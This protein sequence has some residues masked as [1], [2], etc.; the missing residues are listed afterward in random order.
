MIY[1]FEEFRT[2][3]PTRL[4]YGLFGWPLGHT[5]SP[6]LHA[7]L[8]EAAH[9]EADYIG[10]AVPPEQLSEAMELARKKLQGINLTI[11][12]KKAVIP[13]LNAI[14][15]SAMDL[16]SVNT[17]HFKDGEAIGYNTD[18]FGFAATLE[19]DGVELR[20]RKVVLLGYGGAAAVMAYHCVQSG[21]H[22]FITGRNME[23]AEALRTQLLSSVPH[24]KIEVCTRRH[25]PKDAQ[26]VINGTPL[27]MFP[28]EEKKPLYFLPRKT[29]YVFDAIY[30]PPLTSTMRL[31]ASKK[32]RTRNG[33]YMLVMQAAAAQTIWNG[34]Q[35]E[36]S[37]CDGICR[38][39]LAKMAKR[40]LN[41]KYGKQNLVLCG[42]MGSGK[43]TVGRKLARLTGLPH[44]D[45]DNY[46]EEK[47]GRKISEIF[48][49]QGEPAFRD[50]ETKYLREICSMDGAVISLGGGAVLRPENV[51][52]IK[53][54]GF[55]IHLDTPFFRIVKN[56]SC[57]THRPLLDNSGDKL[58]ETRRLYNA[59]K[60][61]YRRAADRSVRSPRL[62]ELVDRLLQSI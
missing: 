40:R 61:I 50:L 10:V 42:F 3:E 20:G 35:F 12:H 24:A 14:D 57:F 46:L 49:K 5:M 54:N 48:E 60:N 39:V 55:L 47:E 59:R 1:S 11:P 27:G 51:E 16:H 26:I 9:V 36:S 31:A 34:T 21:A 8:F 44:I 17:V 58:A 62:S 38:R 45:A 28:H 22:L 29:E 23:K 30:N 56:L 15:Q 13:L 33:L 4:T 43:T 19:K 2:F 53:Q 37:V 41:E 18:I 6:E 32:T 52:I 7:Q 25:I